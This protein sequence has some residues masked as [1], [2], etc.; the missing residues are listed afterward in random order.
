MDFDMNKFINAYH[1]FENQ[2]AGLDKSLEEKEVS[3][4]PS[5]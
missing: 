3:V 1:T 2:K 5:E 4:L